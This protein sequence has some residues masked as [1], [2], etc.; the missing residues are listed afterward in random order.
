MHN[1]AIALACLTCAGHGRQ[2]QTSPGQASR[3]RGHTPLR[4]SRHL[5]FKRASDEFNALFLLLRASAPAAAFSHRVSA[6]RS[7]N[8]RW[9]EPIRGAAIGLR[10]SPAPLMAR[11]KSR[12]ARSRERG[13][14][15]GERMRLKEME[16]DHKKFNMSEADVQKLIMNFEKRISRGF[17]N[18]P[19]Q[20]FKY[21][22]VMD[23]EAT[24]DESV[25]GSYQHEII[26]FPVV[27]VNLAGASIAGEFHSYVRPTENTELTEFCRQLTGITQE[28][29]DAA[30][31]LPEVLQSF[32]EWMSEKGL[33]YTDHSQD[34]AFATHGPWDLRY[35]LHNECERKG[36]RKPAYF[37]K[38][39]NIK[40]SYSR[41]Y[42]MRASTIPNMLSSQ[43]MEFQGK[44]HSGIDDTRNI[45]RLVM[46]LVKDGA[47]L[48]QNEAIPNVEFKNGI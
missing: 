2:V 43:G 39:C 4:L 37:D 45:A 47:V 17:N 20:P 46:K 6:V 34:F 5:G 44:L 3:A 28:Q 9:S 15:K 31:T 40:R 41:R 25:F 12:R 38:W 33:V 24:C 10:R 1:F 36:F 30:P 21:M 27:L 13:K 16:E 48:Y 42:G 19:E 29:V 8:D 32:D 26:E 23:F 11:M 22:C 35:F 14:I 7:I 18:I